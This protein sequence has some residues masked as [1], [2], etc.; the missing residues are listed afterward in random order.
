M[1]ETLLQLD[2]PLSQE[3]FVLTGWK[4]WGFCGAFMFTGRWFVQLFYSRRAKRPT[5]PLGYW[6]M[7]LFGSFM[8]LSYF[9]F[10]KNDSVGILSNLFPS[11]VATYN[12]VLELKHR[13]QKTEEAGV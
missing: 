7:S 3:T 12:L 10:G 13:K 9:I 8:L 4:I 6:Y 11:F 5:F 2:L 1:N